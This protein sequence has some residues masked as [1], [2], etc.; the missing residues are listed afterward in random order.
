MTLF[1]LADQAQLAQEV[2]STA[3]AGALHTHG[4]Q[5]AFAQRAGITPVF[6]NNIIKGK[7]M[8]SLAMARRLA[9]LLP[10]CGAEQAAWLEQVERYWQARR[11][12]KTGIEAR[13]KDDAAAVVRDLVNLRLS[14]FTTDP[15]AVRRG[16]SLAVH[17]GE[18][19]APY[20]CAREHASLYLEYCDVMFEAYSMLHRHVDALSIAKR[21]Q[22]VTLM[23]DDS[24]GQFKLHFGRD[25]FDM[26]KVNALRLEMVA[27][28]ELGMCK[29]AYD[30]SLA[31]EADPACRRKADFWKSVLVWD[32]LNAM[33]H[34]LRASLREA[35][36]ITYEAWR[37][38]ERLADSWQPLGHM[39]VARS[40]A[41]V[42]LSR[43]NWREAR[44]VLSRYLPTL[45]RLP[46]CGVFH[47]VLFL[48][49]WART[50]R[51][52]GEW[53][54][55][56]STIGEAIAR[57][58]QSWLAGVDFDLVETTAP[59]E[60]IALARQAGLVNELAAIERESGHADV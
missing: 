25:E 15:H 18:A 24:P 60:A 58:R 52:Q 38:C 11:G 48:R 29:Q 13:V 45:D 39:L 10:L 41:N 53:D 44:A 46:H 31:I 6:V 47:K 56:R 17:I 40:Y 54:E 30:V 59:G 35:R 21:K 50:L 20:L 37:V 26:H 1:T 34:L 22:L 42:C 57:A 55:W 32:R 2:I 49:A 28:N 3:L 16:W 33:E 14:T 5:K 8:P 27:L 9:P 4:S 36:R 19:V 51:A 43:G 12:V 23:V 7:R